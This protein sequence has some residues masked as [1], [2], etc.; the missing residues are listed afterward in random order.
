MTPSAD[1]AQGSI[2]LGRCSITP[3]LDSVVRR[4]PTAAYAS[5]T[6]AQ[7][8]EHASLLEDD[9]MLALPIGAYL[10][11]TG[12]RV[13]LVD[14][15]IGPDDVAL[16]GG[17]VFPGGSLLENLTATGTAPDDITDVVFT[18]LHID[19]IGWAARGGRPVFSNADYRC[20]AADWDY[21]VLGNGAGAPGG[22]L[23][24][25]R[26]APLFERI[27]TWDSSGNLFEGF[28]VVETPGH[29]PGSSMIVLSSGAMRAVLLGDV[30]HCPVELV[31]EEWE[32]IGDVDPVLARRT[33][34]RLARELEGRETL[35][36]A[37]HF[38][39]L[40]FGRLLVGEGQRSWRFESDG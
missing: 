36:G 5:T 17:A 28:D 13:V 3:V 35:I 38:K 23:V 12:D 14:A 6:E 26:L 16:P 19:H 30:V 11:R 9:G 25:E 37:A 4:L 34:T 20:H 29:T 40:R 1:H 18:H 39:E 31:D 22:D 32:T 33:A 10:V 7:W 15:G 2:D 21:F 8:A 24:A 27:T